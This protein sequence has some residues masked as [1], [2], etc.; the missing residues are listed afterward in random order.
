MVHF[1]LTTLH[2]FISK[3]FYILP[4]NQ[5]QRPENHMFKYLRFVFLR[6]KPW[7]KA[8]G[9][10][11]DLF[12]PLFPGNS[13]SLREVQEGTRREK[14]KQ[15]SQSSV[16]QRLT[17]RGLL[18]LL[19]HTPHNY[20]L[21]SGTIHSDLGPSTIII[22]QENIQQTWPQTIIWRIFFN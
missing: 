2:D 8:I 3:L 17:L 13:V 7:P 12:H 10:G 11:K 15:I 4:S 9:G 21:R 5:L 19:S 1:L 6:Q 20:L 18:S 22:N 14:L 16:V